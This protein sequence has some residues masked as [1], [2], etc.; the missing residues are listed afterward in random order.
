MKDSLPSSIHPLF[1]ARRLLPG[2][3]LRQSLAQLA[4][5]QNISAGAI[6]TCVGSLSVAHLRF[7]NQSQGTSLPGPWEILALAGTLS[8]HGL[9]LHLT[10]GD[11]AGQVRGGHLLPGCLIYTTAEVVVAELPGVIFQRSPDPHTGYRELTI[12]PR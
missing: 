3:D 4:T 10:L 5:D 1:H 2:T 9:H 7:A 8:C 11:S 6:A 12:F